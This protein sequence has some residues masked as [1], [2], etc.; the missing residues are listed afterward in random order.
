LSEMLPASLK[1]AGILRVATNMPYPPWEMY[2]EE[3]GDIPTGLDCDLSHALAVKLGLDWSFDQTAF[4]SIIPSILAG[5]EDIMM[6]GMFDSVERQEALDFVDYATDGYALV[7]AKGNPE[8][9]ETVDDLAGKTVSVQASTMADTTLTKLSKKFVADGKEAMNIMRFAG[10]TE[11]FLAV[12][13]G[14]AQARI[15]SVSVGAYAAKTYEGGGAFEVSTDPSVEETFGS[16]IV[17]IGVSKKTPEL[18]AALQAALQEL[19]DDGTYT[20]IL[21]KYG[22]E[23]LAVESAGV[24]QGVE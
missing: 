20:K 15:T 3:G 23:A 24:N 21:T 12:K 1:S 13:S 19:M 17:G 5:K 18:T 9:I 8:G 11:A 10:D 14:K 16:G 4:D 6:A 22:L 7:V 2:T